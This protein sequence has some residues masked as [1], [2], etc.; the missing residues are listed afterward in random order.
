LHVATS[1]PAEAT[2][3]LGLTEL[4]LHGLELNLFESASV[5]HPNLCELRRLFP[6]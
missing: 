4:V 5:S 2:S 1:L 6:I 3:I